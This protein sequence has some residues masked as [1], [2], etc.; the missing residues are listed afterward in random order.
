MFAFVEARD[1]PQAQSTGLAPSLYLRCVSCMLM[2]FKNAGGS[3]GSGLLVLLAG[4]CVHCVAKHLQPAASHLAPAAT[5]AARQ[6]GKLTAEGFRCLVSVC[7][8]ER[9]MRPHILLSVSHGASELGIANDHGG[10]A[11][12]H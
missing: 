1:T 11:D 4:W 10:N 7:P 3:I 5:A 9:S 6:A 8:L 2:S 12:F